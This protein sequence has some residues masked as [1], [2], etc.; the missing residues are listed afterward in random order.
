M[1]KTTGA[2]RIPAVTPVEPQK[3]SKNN[4]KTIKNTVQNFII[5]PFPALLLFKKPMETDVH[6]I[7]NAVSAATKKISM[8][9]FPALKQALY[10]ANIPARAATSKGIII[11]S[12]LTS[13]TGASINGCGA[14][15]HISHFN[16]ARKDFNPWVYRPHLMRPAPVFHPS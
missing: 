16:A 15:A 11:I 4:I 8:P 14:A 13:L 3:P 7:N 12:H 5:G 1:I 9:V 6:N 2:T 10:S